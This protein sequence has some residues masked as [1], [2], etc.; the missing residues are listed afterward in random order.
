MSYS[1]E[2]PAVERGDKAYH[3]ILEGL[4]AR[5]GIG[6]VLCDA[7]DR[8]LWANDWVTREFPSLF[9]LGQEFTSTLERI[10]SPDPRTPDGGGPLDSTVSTGE[11]YR[12]DRHDGE[13]ACYRHL[14]F[15]V[16]N[17]P[18]AQRVHCLVNVSG[19]KKLEENFL[20]NLHQLSSMREIIDI[21]YEN[22]STQQVL[23]LILVAVTAHMG[24]GFNRAF[25]LEACGGRLRGKIG[26]GPSSVDDA[27]R[28]WTRLAQLNLPTLRAHYQELTR[29]GETPDPQT[30]EIARRM[31]FPT[32]A[33]SDGLLGAIE[34]GKPTLIHARKPGS[35]VDTALFE[36]LRTDAVAVVPLHVRNALAGVLLADNFITRKPIT[37]QDLS[38]L[39]TFSGYAGVALERSQLHDELRKSVNKLQAAN[40]SL[41]NNQRKLLQAEKLSAIGELAACVSHEIRNPLVAIGG[42]ARSLLKEP[43]PNPDS[44]ESLQ[45]IVT[46]VARL[47]KFLRETL[48]FVKP[49]V[50]GTDS[51]DLREEVE[52]CLA[53]FH[54]EFSENAVSVQLD[55]GPEPLT[56]L[57]DRDLFRRA[58][59]NLIKNA[60]DA[61]GMYGTICLTARR[62]GVSARVSVAD[63]GSG[64]PREIRSRIFEPFF[65]TKDD[66]TGLGLAIA[67]QSIRSLGGQISLQDNDRYRT[68]L[69]ISLPLEEAAASLAVS[70][71]GS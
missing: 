63:T 51:V 14:E 2:D 55:L 43:M 7:V 45:I 64:I 59:S 17:A 71:E 40:E 10:S 36:L 48:D 41:K 66:G 30:R 23:Y 29:N 68:I 35:K 44:Q 42:L 50:M 1:G 56:C 11:V 6:V 22:L 20:K 58:L 70:G 69:N 24:F 25:Y 12:L 65:T 61:I 32:G 38:V 33:A 31:D 47:E 13:P 57:I 8:I 34:S 62:H 18:S 26:I 28:I 67:S 37:D 4:S 15:A 53:P 27:H 39:K 19:E 5:L 3:T 60:I 54:S 21:L 49:E 46:E 9:P 52:H 16:C